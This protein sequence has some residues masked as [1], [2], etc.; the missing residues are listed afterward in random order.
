MAV[1]AVQSAENS[2][3]VAANAILAGSLAGASAENKGRYLP[4]WIRLFWRRLIFLVDGRRCGPAGLRIGL[5]GLSIS[6]S[7]FM[8]VLSLRE[9]IVD[10]QRVIPP[11][12]LIVTLAKCRYQNHPCTEC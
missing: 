5:N 10:A 7:I 2:A 3:S 9:I 11:C 6:L 4:F 8:F 12:L 1:Q